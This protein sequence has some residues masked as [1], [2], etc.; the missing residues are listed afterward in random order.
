RPALRTGQGGKSGA[1]LPFPRPRPPSSRRL[2]PV[3]LGALTCRADARSRAP[4]G[5][6]RQAKG[7]RGA[8]ARPGG[9]GSPPT[10]RERPP[11]VVRPG[12]LSRLACYASGG[13]TLRQS[14]AHP[15]GRAWPSAPAGKP[16]AP[17]TQL[18]LAAARARCCV[19]EF[20]AKR[21]WQLVSSAGC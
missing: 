6:K 14:L 18:H 12:V 2:R 13:Q 5:E 15:A 21:G 3:A 7:Q 4:L 1:D 16:V 8:N 20:G 11:C 9:G 19:G 17:W 10:A